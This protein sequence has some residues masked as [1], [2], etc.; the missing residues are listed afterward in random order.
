MERSA[1]VVFTGVLEERAQ[2]SLQPVPGQARSGVY[3]V[4]TGGDSGDFASD[5][6]EFE[7]GTEYVPNVI[8][9]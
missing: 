9:Q 3:Y 6:W 1:L 4:C 5:Y 7:G 2:G 8:R